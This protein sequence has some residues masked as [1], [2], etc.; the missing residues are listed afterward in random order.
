MYTIDLIRCCPVYYPY[1]SDY[2]LVVNA[3]STVARRDVPP[4]PQSAVCCQVRYNPLLCKIVLAIWSWS[5]LQFTMVLTATK[6]RKDHS[7]VLSRSLDELNENTCC[8]PD[9]YGI[10]ISIIMQDAPFLVLRMLLIFRYGDVSPLWEGT[11]YIRLHTV[12]V[13]YVILIPV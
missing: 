8:T 6:A 1:V 7:C 3:S 9:V 5:L 13:V 2:G 11:N 12:H 4:C 10:I